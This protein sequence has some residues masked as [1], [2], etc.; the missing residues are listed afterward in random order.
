[1]DQRIWLD[2][3]LQIFWLVMARLS[4]GVMLGIGE[5]RSVCV[6]VCVCVCVF[7]GVEGSEGGRTLG[8]HQNN[9]HLVCLGKGAVL[10]TRHLNVK[11]G[12]Q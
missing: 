5:M 3:E 11:L 12:N 7:R 6:C 1:M 9:R 10:Y 4:D 2:C 8:T